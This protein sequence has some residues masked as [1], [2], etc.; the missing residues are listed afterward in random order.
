MQRTAE[1]R[2]RALALLL[3]DQPPPHPPGPRFDGA[4]AAHVDA[5]AHSP[6]PPTPGQLQPVGDLL[7]RLERL[8]AEVDRAPA[9]AARERAPARL[10]QLECRVER[11]GLK[12]FDSWSGSDDNSV[13]HPGDPDL[14]GR[15]AWAAA[16][17]W[18]ISTAASSESAGNAA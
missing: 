17:A 15:I 1:R 18:A 16:L 2:V 11:T 14:P 12:P 6:T 3:L 5:R 9:R 10:D 7:D 13:L 8:V 4:V